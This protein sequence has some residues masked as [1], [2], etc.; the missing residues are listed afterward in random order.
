VLYV[1]QM[2][3]DPRV[4]SVAAEAGPDEV[5][6]V[7]GAEGAD[8]KLVYEPSAWKPWHIEPYKSG[9]I[10]VSETNDA[11]MQMVAS[12]SRRSGPEVVLIDHS[13]D[14]GGWFEQCM[15]ARHPVFGPWSILI[16]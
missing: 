10:A 14:V 12:C 6:W 15:K 4:I 5:R 3:V 16:A 7:E 9:V 11:K 1:I 13:K 8:L 2:G